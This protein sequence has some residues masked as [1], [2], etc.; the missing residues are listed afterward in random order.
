MRVTSKKIDA[1]VFL[2]HFNFNSSSILLLVRETYGTDII[3]ESTS[4]RMG[5]ATPS[6]GEH[7]D[8]KVV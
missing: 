6:A 4:I 5:V 7:A 2:H 1:K 3:D 8:V